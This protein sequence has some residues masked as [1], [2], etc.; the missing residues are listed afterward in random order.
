MTAAKE[1]GAVKPAKKAGT[2]RIAVIRIR[3]EVRL[4]MPVQDTLHMLHLH[5]RN[6]ASVFSPTPV[7]MGMIT[8]VKDYVTYGEIDDET[9]KLLVEK[10]GEEYLGHSEK[11]NA[12]KEGGKNLK[13][14]FRLSPPRKGYGRKGVKIPFVSGGALGNRGDKINDLIRRMI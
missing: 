11:K 7:S 1:A 5:R 10:R 9:Y 4:D 14:F 13:P 2:S 8:K 6:Y 3:G 12:V